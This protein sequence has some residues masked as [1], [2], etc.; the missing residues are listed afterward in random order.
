MNL[1][2]KPVLEVS[3]MKLFRA[4]AVLAAA[5][6]SVLPV[7]TVNAM[8]RSARRENSLMN[9]FDAV[10]PVLVAMVDWQT[11]MQVRDG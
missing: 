9:T 3:S 4:L 5:A 7:Y 2:A 1:D 11:S 10:T 8:V 6:A